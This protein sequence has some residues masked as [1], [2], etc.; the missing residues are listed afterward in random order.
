MASSQTC[1]FTWLSSQASLF[2]ESVED[3]CAPAGAQKSS[4]LSNKR[5]AGALKTAQTLAF[6]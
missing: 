6:S 3:F 4:T 5:A 1:F 2:L